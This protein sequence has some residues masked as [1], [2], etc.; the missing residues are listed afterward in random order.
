VTKDFAGGRTVSSLTAV[1]GAERASE[2]ARM[3]G[4]KGASALAHANTLLAG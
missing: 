1:E 3:L 4:G 2:I